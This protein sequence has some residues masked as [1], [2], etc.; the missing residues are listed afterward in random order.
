[1]H[2]SDP[3]RSGRRGR[4]TATE[5]EE[6]IDLEA[7]DKQDTLDAEVTDK[8]DVGKKDNEN[9]KT[10]KQPTFLHEQP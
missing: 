6:A 2:R 9:D 4:W 3:N 5:L 8:Q 7:A 10:K 1:M